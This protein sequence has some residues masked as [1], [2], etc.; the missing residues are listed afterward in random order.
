MAGEN[1]AGAGQAPSATPLDLASNDEW[2]NKE[3][4][5]RKGTETQFGHCGS[6]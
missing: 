4:K 2:L 1:V 5:H 6:V 3:D